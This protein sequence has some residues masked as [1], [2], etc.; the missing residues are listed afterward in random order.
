MRPAQGPARS[1][2]Q[3]AGLCGIAKTKILIADKPLG[4]GPLGQRL[5]L[6]M[7]IGQKI[8]QG[9]SRMCDMICACKAEIF[10]QERQ[11]TWQI[12]PL[13]KEG[14][15]AAELKR[16]YANAS[17]DFTDDAALMQSQGKKVSFVAGEV[18]A[19]KITTPEDLL[20]V[21]SR[22][23]GPGRTG[24]GVDVH[25][26]STDPSKKLYLGTIEW[27]GVPGLD[28]HSDGD[29]VSHAIVDA[30]LSAAGLGDIG[31]NFGVDHPEFSG[32]NGSVF[33]SETVRMVREAGFE[34]VNVSVQLI[35]NRPKVS[36]KRTEAE[37]AWETRWIRGFAQAQDRKA[38]RLY[39]YSTSREPQEIYRRCAAASGGDFKIVTMQRGGIFGAPAK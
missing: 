34:V 36:T 24:I 37:K 21:L 12:A 22:L 13:Q 19:A 17:D 20:G 18:E 33:L 35:G 25:R 5:M 14:F 9:P 38:P 15:I 10:Q 39:L 6:G 3:I 28:G 8:R 30:L 29:A 32:A 23:N 7:A 16:A 31:S 4:S 27:P 2:C 1:V 26:F 11:Q